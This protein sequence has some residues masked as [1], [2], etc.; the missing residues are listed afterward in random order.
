VN[1][2]PTASASSNSPVCVG[3]T[4]T[5]F[6]NGGVTYAWSG[7]S[8]FTSNLQN[9][10]RTPVVAGTY[11]VTVTNAAGCTHTASTSVST[12]ALPTATVTG[13]TSICAG[14]ILS[15][16]ASSGVSYAWSG[17]NSFTGTGSV[18]SITNASPV[19]SGTYVVTVTNA[20][21]CQKTAS[22]TVTVNPTPAA[23]AGSNSPVCLGSTINLT[24]S[25][26]TSYLWNGPGGYSSSAQNPVRSGATALMAGTY[27]VTV[28]GAGGCTATAST[29]VVV[30]SCGAPL[31]ITSYVITKNSSMTLAG[32]GSILLNVSGG[33]PCTGGA[34]YTYAW[35]PATGSM[36][37]SA[38]THTYSGLSQG[39]YTVTITDCGGNSITQTFYVSNAIRGFKT[40]DATFGELTAYPNPISNEATITFTSYVAEHIRLAIYTVDGKEVGILFDGQ[41]EENTEYVLKFNMSELP[42]ATYYALLE[43]ESGT[44][45]TIRLVVFR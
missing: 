18:I 41:T 30:N 31:V 7:P 43:A 35:S 19:N 26:G 24:S 17:P 40:G 25:G 16:T 21:G 4:L 27:T 38:G 11:T 39:F 22:R 44:S 3:S 29:V 34:Y 36:S 45:K 23:T 15:L 6:G 32:N 1:T 37:S 20:A 10:T 12:I 28:T 33:V 9:P 14:T 2:P 42:Q 13:S 8:S 5:L